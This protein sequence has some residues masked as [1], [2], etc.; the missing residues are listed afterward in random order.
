MG[1]Q[2]KLLKVGDWV[3]VGDWDTDTGAVYL[4]FAGGD[5]GMDK[6][7]GLYSWFF[8]YQRVCMDGNEEEDPVLSPF[9]F[10]DKDWD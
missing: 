2:R 6:G 4:G 5:L 7:Q 9:L 1:D 8:S 3:Q 10:F